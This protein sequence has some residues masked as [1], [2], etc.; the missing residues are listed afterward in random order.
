MEVLCLINNSCDVDDDG[1]DDSNITTNMMM[2]LL[3]G[4]RDEKWAH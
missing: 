3:L 4:K 2:L 1:G